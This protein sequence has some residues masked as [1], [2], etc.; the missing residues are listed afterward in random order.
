[1]A[2]AETGSKTRLAAQLGVS[3]SSLYYRHK[4]SEKDEQLRLSPGRNS[5]EDQ[6][7]TRRPSHEEVRAQTSPALEDAQ[8][9]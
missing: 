6:R 8:K 3:R 5:A 9:N 7:E 4:M 2:A 1:V